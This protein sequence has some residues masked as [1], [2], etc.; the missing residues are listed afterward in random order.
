MNESSYCS[1]SSPAFGVG[2]DMDLGH[3]NKCVVIPCFNLHFSDDL[4]CGASFV[5]LFAICVSSLVRCLLRS[6]THILIGLLVTLLLS[7]ES[8]LYILDTVFFQMCLLQIFSPSLWLVF[9]FS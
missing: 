7:F 9:S 5:C 1:P 3:P 8:S 2:S 4:R 6:L